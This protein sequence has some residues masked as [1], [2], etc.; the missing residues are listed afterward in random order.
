MDRIIYNKYSNERDRR[1]NIRTEIAVDEQGT[2]KVRK[3]AACRDSIPHVRRMYDMCRRFQKQYEGSGVQV[4]PCILE[5]DAACFAYMKGHNLKELM[6]EA[7]AR[8]EQPEFYRMFDRFTTFVRAQGE[9]VSDEGGKLF[10]EIFGMDYPAGWDSL[11][12]HC[13]VNLDLNFDN[14]IVDGDVWTVLDYE[15]SFD[16]AVPVEFLLYRSVFYLIYQSPYQTELEAMKLYERAGVPA[17]YMDCFAQMEQAFQRYVVGNAREVKQYGNRGINVKKLMLQRVWEDREIAFQVYE[18]MGAGIREEDSCRVIAELNEE[19]RFQFRYTP[20]ENVSRLRIDPGDT[21]ILLHFD[22]AG[23]LRQGQTNGCWLNEQTIYFPEADPWFELEHSGTEITICGRA[24]KPDEIVRRALNSFLQENERQKGQLSAQEEQMSAQAEQLGALQEQLRDKEQLKEQ[25][26]TVLNSTSW[27]ATAWLRCISGALRGERRTDRERP[28][29][30]VHLHLFYTDLLDEFLGYFA[31][32]PYPFDLYVSCVKGADKGV[33]RQNARERLP[34]LRRA[35]VHICENRGRDIAPF[36]VEFGKE[37]VQYQYVLHVHSKKSKHIQEGGAE[38]RRY[39]LDSLLGTRELTG[40][41][42]HKFMKE[43]DVGLIYP[44]W[45]PDIPMIGYTWMGNGAGGQALLERMGIPYHE[46]LFF[47]PT[48]SFFWARV[49]AIRPL[50]EQGFTNKDFPPEQGQIDGTLAH[51]LERAIAFVAKSRGYHSYIVDVA[52][53]AMRR[54]RT[55]KP[56]REYL[57]KTEEAALQ[58]LMQYESISFGVFGTLI[59]FLP[60][61]EEDIVELVRKRLGLDEVFVA[62]RR[63][64]ERRARARCGSATTIDEIYAELVTISPFDEGAAAQLKQAE[65]DCIGSN[66][67]PRIRMREIYR[68]LI[69]AGKQVAVVCDTY[70]HKDTIE[71]LLV[72]CGYIGYHKIWVSCEHGV[73]KRDE[74]MWNLVYADYD[75]AHH[76][77]VGCDAYADWYTLERRGTRSMYVMSARQAYELSAVYEEPS[78]AMTLQDSLELGQKVKQELFPSPFGLAGQK[79]M[80]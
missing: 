72:K 11:Q 50:F 28:G 3:Y 25:L 68:A 14:V 42:L 43:P 73:S 65:L 46:G 1:F 74:Q 59:E 51:V 57:A 47:Y 21:A 19:K 71:A 55:M 41:I 79:E 24:G 29:I 31:N 48:G 26:N 35:E 38:W 40:E 77:H 44:D 10:R 58:E 54:D 17:E 23:I 56:F 67:R 34:M 36:Y 60:Y 2:R 63:E 80:C 61:R 8:N 32:I 6:T 53:H 37:L 39:S 64:A 9:T 78:L 45:H 13:P 33:I 20:R 22:E 70:Y 12:V 62:L 76:I 66:V 27:R 15:W 18:D 4:C 75:P 5:G 49:D 69:R 16:M 7:V 30:A 52:E